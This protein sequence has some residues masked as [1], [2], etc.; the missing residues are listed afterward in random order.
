[1]LESLSSILISRD[2]MSPAEAAE[3]IAEAKER[4]RNGEDPEEILAEDFGL[5]PD[6]IFELID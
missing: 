3:F 6:Y 4:V 5:E 2:G 1:M